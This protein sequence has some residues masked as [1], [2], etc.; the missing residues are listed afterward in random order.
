[1]KTIK[2]AIL[3]TLQENFKEGAFPNEIYEHIAKQK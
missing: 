3:K 1:M 2:E